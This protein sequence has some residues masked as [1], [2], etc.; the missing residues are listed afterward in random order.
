[1]EHPA[2]NQNTDPDTS[3]DSDVDGIAASF[4]GSFPDLAKNVAVLSLSISTLTSGPTR[5]EILFLSG[6]LSQPGIFGAQTTSC[7]EK[8]IPGTHIPTAS[9]LSPRQEPQRALMRSKTMS[10]T[11]SP[12]APSRS[13]TCLA[14]IL[15]EASKTAPS[16][17]VPPRSIAITAIMS[18][19]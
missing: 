13:L 9:T 19:R 10:P 6:Y 7:L 18:E 17:F 5:P 2:V 11:A 15:P 14:H 4:G 16:A 8:T 12:F 1:M 3:P